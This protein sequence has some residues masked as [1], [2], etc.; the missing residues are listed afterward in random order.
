M[1]HVANLVRSKGDPRIVKTGPSALGWSDTLVRSRG[2]FSI[3]LGLVALVSPGRVTRALGMEGKERLVQACGAREI[4]QGLLALSPDKR[5]ASWSR[6]AGDGLDIAALMTGLRKDNPKRENVVLALG[7]VVGATVVDIAIAQRTSA[8]HSRGRGHQRRY[9]D[10]SG[11]P[12]GV[13]AARGAARKDFETPADMR[14]D[15]VSAPG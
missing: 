5:A 2:W 7:L 10:R 6:V 14:A 11:F 15:L 3:G 1:V 12:G 13:E 9:L 4:G 8:R